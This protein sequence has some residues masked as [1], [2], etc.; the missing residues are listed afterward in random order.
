M[1]PHEAH[2]YFRKRHARCTVAYRYGPSDDM[3]VIL[4]REHDFELLGCLL[5]LVTLDV[6]VPISE[7]DA[8]LAITSVVARGPPIVDGDLEGL[9]G[10]GADSLLA[11]S[12]FDLL[13]YGFENTTP[14]FAG[15]RR[16]IVISL[17]LD[18]IGDGFKCAVPSIADLGKS[19]LAGTSTSCNERLLEQ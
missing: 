14:S 11:S 6:V 3:K 15:I 9:C 2:Q 1:D 12:K 7:E 10:K 5:R 13:G 19:I 17:R 18:L 4:L 8:D 16:L